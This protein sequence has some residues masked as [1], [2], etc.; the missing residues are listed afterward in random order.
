[1]APTI[2]IIGAGSAIF[3]R[4]LVRDICSYPALQE[5]TIRLVDIDQ[6]RLDVA[7]RAV[8]SIVT[9][10]GYPTRVET[11]LD[12]TEALP[13][14]DAVL[15]TIQVGGEQHLRADLEI[16]QRYGVNL[17][18]GDTRGPAGVFRFLR[19][20][21]VLQT[22]VDDIG[23]YAPGAFFLNYTNPMAMLSGLLQRTSAVPV[24]GLCHS[25]QRTA[26]MLTRWIGAQ[27]EEMS[28][29]CA[30]VNHQAWYVRFERNGED[31]YPQ[32]REALKDP[33]RWNEEPVRN[34][35]FR[36][37]GLYVTESSGHNSEY[38]W[39]YRKR[40]DL[41]R[42]YVDPATGEQP[43]VPFIVLKEMEPGQNWR[44]T[45]FQEFLAEPVDLTR[46]DEFAPAILD[47]TLGERRPLVFYGNVLNG[48]AV[49]NL[50]ADANVE[51]PLT[52]SVG[53]FSRHQVGPLP[54]QVAALNFVN[55]T[56]DN[57]AVEGYLEKDPDKI[58]QAIALD[59]LT[60]A[61]LSLEEVHDMVGEMFSAAS[62][63]LAE[64]QR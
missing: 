30:G 41:I 25:V 28:Y 22:I 54:A 4:N 58:F 6:G 29:V 44:N 16:P 12:R 23:H 49:T 47:A 27:P 39:W 38:N 8:G 7:A 59:P 31:A 64:F 43:G 19:T 57:L 5:S 26:Q 21:P 20:A 18:I 56:A 11:Y 14:A 52:A 10:G 1:M 63:W 61:T 33:V 48:T 9:T 46:G 37:L 62:G 24:I 32:V 55:A 60:A 40:E 35:M 42:K 36:H 50:P 45:T 17:Y 13:G 51:I 15:S 53:G 2:V 34:D 3:T